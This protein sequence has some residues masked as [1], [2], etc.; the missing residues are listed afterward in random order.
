M[1]SDNLGL[2]SSDSDSNSRGAAGS[3]AALGARPTGGSESNFGRSPG[4]LITD[5]PAGKADLGTGREGSG[6]L[7]GSDDVTGGPLGITRVDLNT[8]GDIR[9][10]RQR[11]LHPEIDPDTRLGLHPTIKAEDLPDSPGDE[12][13]RSAATNGG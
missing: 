9:Q 6:Q 1:A 12:P 13:I 8:G 3:D 5:Q 11:E 2:T 10:G 7:P 4:D